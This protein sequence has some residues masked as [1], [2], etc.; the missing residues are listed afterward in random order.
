MDVFSEYSTYLRYLREATNNLTQLSGVSWFN[1]SSDLENSVVNILLK[2]SNSLSYLRD[3]VNSLISQRELT[4][5]ILQEVTKETLRL[6]TNETLGELISSPRHVLK[7]TA[8]ETQDKA[9]CW[10]WVFG[11]SINISLN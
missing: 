10:L 8:Q 4:N 7:Q 5:Q 11:K 6:A 2:A 9:N 1:L 3:V